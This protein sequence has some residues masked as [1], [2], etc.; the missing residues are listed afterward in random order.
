MGGMN[1]GGEIFNSGIPKKDFLKGE[2]K[3]WVQIFVLIKKFCV[4][5]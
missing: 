4:Y 5:L 2:F 3:M 1:E